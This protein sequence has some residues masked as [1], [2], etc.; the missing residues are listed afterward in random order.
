MIGDLGEEARRSCSRASSRVISKM[1]AS[2]SSAGFMTEMLES[3]GESSF[4]TRALGAVTFVA[5]RSA[6]RRGSSQKTSRRS[7]GSFDAVSSS[8]AERGLD[9]ASR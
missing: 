2:R 7:R 3:V 5:L 1:R 8:I 9:V 6:E 4:G